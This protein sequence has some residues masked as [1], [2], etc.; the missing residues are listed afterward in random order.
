M[1]AQHV[2]RICDQL[3][4]SYTIDS[5]VWPSLTAPTMGKLESSR[6]PRVWGSIFGQRLVISFPHWSGLRLASK[7]RTGKVRSSWLA[8]SLWRRKIL[9]S[10]I[11][12]Q[13]YSNRNCIQ[14]TE[15]RIHTLP[16]FAS[17]VYINFASKHFIHGLHRCHLHN[18]TMRLVTD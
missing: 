2:I 17:L 9:D 18:S 5:G 1:H 7:I 12:L 10:K 6:P 8:I 15:G 14:L 16:F 4:Q 3:I 11:Q 13:A